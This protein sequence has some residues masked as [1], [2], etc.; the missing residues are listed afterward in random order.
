MKRNDIMLILVPS[1][2]FV[3]FWVVFNVFHNFQSST[4]PEVVGI[5]INPI[6][7]NFDENTITLLKNRQQINPLY[8]LTPSAQTLENS[9]TSTQ[10]ALSQTPIVTPTGT[11]NQ[12]QASTGGSLGP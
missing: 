9:P 11:S 5:Q 4:I 12:Q 1:L 2:L 8:Q 3:I 10:S 6:N 7:P